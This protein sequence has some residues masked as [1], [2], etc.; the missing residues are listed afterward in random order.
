LK[1]LLMQNKIEL[2]DH[3]ELLQQLRNLE[4][5]KTRA[6][7]DMRPGGSRRDDLAVAIALVAH[8]LSKTSA[9]PFPE[10]IFRESLSL[11]TS[12]YGVQK[13]RRSCWRR[14]MGFYSSRIWRGAGRPSA[15]SEVTIVCARAFP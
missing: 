8:E 5:V 10:V 2:L 12:G 6:G 11:S 15:R 1:H 4:E 9:Q 7:I 3:S 14:L 13:M